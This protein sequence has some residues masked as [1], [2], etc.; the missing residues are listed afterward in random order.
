MVPG[1]DLLPTGTPKAKGVMPKVGG[2][3][4]H[5]WEFSAQPSVQLGVFKPKDPATGPPLLPQ[6]K[7]ANSCSS[8]LH[9]PF[10]SPAA[11]G[12]PEAE[13]AVPEVEGVVH[14]QQVGVIVGQLAEHVKPHNAK[15]H[16]AIGQ[17]AN[18]I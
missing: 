1:A 13:V 15:V 9:V 2:T 17:L 6:A 3:M 8:Q 5:Q 11:H 18:H 14:D 16:V 7:V 10:T 4:H 12:H